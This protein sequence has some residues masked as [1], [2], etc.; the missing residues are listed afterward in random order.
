MGKTRYN[1]EQIV[2]KLR[3]V[4]A[5]ISQG[6]NMVDAIRQIGVG[7]PVRRR[8]RPKS[9]ALWISAE[10]AWTSAASAVDFPLRRCPASSRRNLSKIR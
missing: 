8:A 6:Q 10:S 7:T 9:Y 1:P 4:D 2:A 5:L 3:Q